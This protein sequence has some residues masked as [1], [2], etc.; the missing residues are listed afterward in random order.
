MDDLAALVEQVPDEIL[1][2]IEKL[3]DQIAAVPTENEPE[4]A[5]EKALG[6]LDPEI[7]KAFTEQRSRLEVAEQALVAEQV[8]KADAVWVS[9][10]RSADGLIDS[11]EDFGKQMRKV[12][13]IDPTLAE[14]VMSILQT[15]SARVAKSDLFSE[16]GRS[17]APASGSVTEKVQNIAKALVEA[18]PTKSAEQAEAEAWE[19]NPELYEAHV[20]ERRDA[21]KS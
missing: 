5:F 6:E 4:D 10:A 20:Q 11:P 18:D 15:A 16:I 2:Y 12:S 17:S 13:T 21:L 8:A 14:S 19:A 7:A 1:D 3:E 9:K